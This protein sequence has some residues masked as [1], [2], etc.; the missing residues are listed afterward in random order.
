MAA[1]LAGNLD[2]STKKLVDVRLV[3]YI[4]IKCMNLN[5]SSGGELYRGTMHEYNIIIAGLS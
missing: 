3:S 2:F 5:R 1:K 4:A